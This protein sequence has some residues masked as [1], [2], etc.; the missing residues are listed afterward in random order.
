MIHDLGI[1]LTTSVAIDV[2][3]RTGDIKLAVIESEN[4]LIA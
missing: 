4:I 2:L 3:S 1:I